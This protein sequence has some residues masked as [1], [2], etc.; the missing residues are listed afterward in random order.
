MG[1]RAKVSV[2]AGLR[3]AYEDFLKRYDTQE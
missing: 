3:A 2:N 1:W